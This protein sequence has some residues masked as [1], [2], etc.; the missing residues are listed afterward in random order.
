MKQTTLFEQKKKKTQKA[1][2]WPCDEA[3]KFP[4]GQKRLDH[5]ENCEVCAQLLHD[6]ENSI[7]L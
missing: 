6:L 3:L 2:R 1:V 4:V 7:E 5:I